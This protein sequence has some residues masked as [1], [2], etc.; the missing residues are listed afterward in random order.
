MTSQNQTQP[1]G[2]QRFT[3]GPERRLKRNADFQRVFAGRVS[4]ADDRL[5]MF[6]AENDLNR[7]RAGICVG[8]K[9]GSAVVRNRYKRVLREAFRTIQHDL[10]G[11]YD[12]VLIPRKIGP[13][14]MEQYRRSLE[15]LV[16]RMQKRAVSK[17][18]RKSATNSQNV[19]KMSPKSRK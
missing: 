9:L 13:V 17:N 3:F 14:R 7:V 18:T 5:I 1:E 8:K 6:V 4:F 12:Y 15:R 16:Q 11:G 10:P 2:K 19:P